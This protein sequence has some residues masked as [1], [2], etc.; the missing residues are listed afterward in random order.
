M[1]W[2]DLPVSVRLSICIVG[3]MVAMFGVASTTQYLTV[4]VMLRAQNMISDY[5]ERMVLAVRWLGAAELTSE[6][7]VG[8]LGTSD[9]DLAARYE[10]EIEAG[11]EQIAEL[12]RRILAHDLSPDDQRFLAAINV[13]SEQLAR[14]V[15]AAEALSSRGDV[16][17]LQAALE[18]QV[19]PAIT[20]YLKS[21]QKF[22]A[23]EEQQRDQMVS[24]IGHERQMQAAAG[25][26]VGAVLLLLGVLIAML[27]ARA[28][29]K[30]LA[31]A[32]KQ[33]EAIAQGRLVSASTHAGRIRRDEF[34]QLQQAQERMASG[35]RTL[36]SQ[37]RNG[38]RSVSVATSGIAAGNQALAARTE[39]AAS[40]L[41]VTTAAM[42]AF[43]GTIAESAQTAREAS[44]LVS[45]A[46]QSATRGGAV[47]HEVIAR[48][49]E[50]SRSSEQIS[51]ITGVIDG[52]AFQTNL[53]ALNA[54]VEAAR[55]GEQGRG[56]AVVAAEVRNL[57]HRSAQAAREIKSLIG[58]SLNTVSSGSV[59]VAQAGEAMTEIVADVQQVSQLIGEITHS[60][61]N[62]INGIHQVNAALGNIDA[63][64][65]QN[66]A[67]V[68]EASLQATAVNSEASALA[69]LVSVF[70]MEEQE[71]DG[72]LVQEA[73]PLIST[74]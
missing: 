69:Q 68:H 51:E 35:L 21:L 5:D 4:R 19:R 24:D 70:E 46:A 55:A 37:V 38:V 61:G 73:A 45:Q 14:E 42:D 74:A 72:A 28:I 3:L 11:R 10:T 67:L 58:A 6:R 54:A 41:Q 60:S 12:K 62:Q 18:N 23:L 59:L 53:L 32:V 33:A 34:G 39:Q 52:I 43:T 8:S 47:M 16:T 30:S 17:G 20:I 40:S 2:N 25:A 50:I 22:V 36:V 63:M 26:F 66:A 29:T 7:V 1:R 31:L 56:F 64:T 71:P 13:A 44:Q 9:G 65:Q 57:A 15:K 27:I 49:D 48:M